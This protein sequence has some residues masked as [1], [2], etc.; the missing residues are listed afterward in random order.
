[1]K[2]AVTRKDRISLETS[3]ENVQNK[4]MKI[5]KEKNEL[6]NKL[7]KV[8]DKITQPYRDTI[9]RKSHVD[10][11][12]GLEDDYEFVEPFIN[13]ELPG[14]TVI[15]LKEKERA[16][17]KKKETKKVK[18]DAKKEEK[19]K[20]AEVKETKKENVAEAKK[21][22]KDKKADAKKEKKVKKAEV[23][24]E[25]KAKKA[26]KKAEKKKAK[27]EKEY[28]KKKA[29]A[30]TK[31][32]NKKAELKKKEKKAKR[33]GDDEKIEKIK[34]KIKKV[35]NKLE[36]K[37]K[38]LKAKKEEKKKV[39]DAKK[40]EK[41]IK[42]KAEKK[43]KVTKAK[44]QEKKKKAKATEK[45]VETIEKAKQV[46]KKEKAKA[47]DKKVEKKADASKKATVK[48]ADLKAREVKV[49]TKE[50]QLSSIIASPNSIYE[51]CLND[52]KKN[53]DIFCIKVNKMEN[54]KKKNTNIYEFVGSGIKLNTF[55]AFDFSDGPN[56]QPRKTSIDNYSKI[57]SNLIHKI[58][59]YAKQ[60]SIYLYGFGA[61][62]NN[63]DVD[64]FN[65]NDGDDLPIS[66]DK[67]G[68]VF[69]SKQNSIKPKKKIILSKLIRKITKIIFKLYEA[70][71]YN[72]LFLFLREIPDNNDKQEIIDS[73]IEASYL[74]LTIIIIG[75]GNNDFN[76]LKEFFGD[77]VNEASSGMIKNRDNI[78]FT[79]FYNNF[80]ENEESFTQC[81]LEELSK[82]MI[83]F[84]DLI[85][86]S[87]QQI[88]K[89]NMRAI[90]KSFMQYNKVSI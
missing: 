41:K 26:E 32:K 25:K 75:E 9:A 81:C 20:K 31:A 71:N 22:E 24:K 45:K 2:Y 86:V 46:M 74:P 87:P 53:E 19:V 43:V 29:S 60:Q 50:T 47:Q 33:E 55:L 88:L 69:S 80:N 4:L 64:L 27:V 70:R 51:R 49:A 16:E 62:F 36:K 11:K 85:K 7:R 8:S 34:A 12:V 18:A 56:K 76:Q 21:E 78:L 54:D 82:Q 17:D 15:D 84:Y 90:E 38:T 65:L 58:Y 3:L 63:H 83:E 37:K 35:L 57:I 77:K 14:Q 10:K 6:M 79:D 72:V 48:K 13:D 42:A 67:V 23:K 5:R 89:N 66:L 44:E 59:F 28:Q 40:G 39:I 30:E 68:R 73:L 52:N 1:M 61:E